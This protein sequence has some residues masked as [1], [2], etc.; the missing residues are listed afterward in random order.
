MVFSRSTFTLGLLLS[1]ATTSVAADPA[2]ACAWFLRSNYANLRAQKLLNL[3]FKRVDHSDYYRRGGILIY[4]RPDGIYSFYVSASSAFMSG[5]QFIGITAGPGYGDLEYGPRLNLYSHVARYANRANSVREEGFDIQGRSL[6][7]RNYFAFGL[8]KLDQTPHRQQLADAGFKPLG[9]TKSLFIVRSFL[10]H[11]ERGNITGFFSPVSGYAASL[12]SD[13]A[14]VLEFKIGSD[15]TEDGVSAIRIQSCGQEF[16]LTDSNTGGEVSKKPLT[17]EE[18][19]D[20]ALTLER[21]SLVRSI[22]SR[23]ERQKVFLEQSTETGTITT[24]Y[25][26]TNFVVRERGYGIVLERRTSDGEIEYLPLIG[27]ITWVAK[28]DGRHQLRMESPSILYGN[29]LDRPL[30]IH[31]GA[32]G[33][34]LATINPFRL[35]KDSS[36]S[37]LKRFIDYLMI[38]HGPA[39]DPFA[40]E[41]APLYLNVHGT[42]VTETVRAELV[43]ANITA[44]WQVSLRVNA[45]RFSQKAPVDLVGRIESIDLRDEDWEV[46]LKLDPS[47][48]FQRAYKDANLRVTFRINRIR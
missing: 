25:Q 32:A 7:V 4:V 16:V 14:E 10:A 23:Y 37:E 13:D 28:E 11:L 38:E 6:I 30:E 45:P 47:A 27:E 29:A 48:S 20:Q 44:A 1:V 40:R 3:G 21:T 34:R 33:I 41:S 22:L 39:S 8:G 19:Q 31:F 42:S 5:N 36:R 46:T 15:A 18:K 12:L 43:G 26:L 35:H 9:G 24:A 2:E 17:G